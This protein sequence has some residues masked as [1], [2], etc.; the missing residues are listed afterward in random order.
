MKKIKPLSG[1]FIDRGFSYGICASVTWFLLSDL[2]GSYIRAVFFVHIISHIVVRVDEMKVTFANVM[3][4]KVEIWN[5]SSQ[6]SSTGVYTS[7][8]SYDML[9]QPFPLLSMC[10]TVRLFANLFKLTALPY[11]LGHIFVWQERE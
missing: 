11:E 6:S 2:G 4:R 3:G 1:P 5:S 8:S 9:I 7:L 10:R